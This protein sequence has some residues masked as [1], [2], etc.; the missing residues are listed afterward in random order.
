M[1]KVGFRVRPFLIPPFNVSDPTVPFIRVSIGSS[2]SLRRNER[3]VYEIRIESVCSGE[4]PEVFSSS[5]DCVL[6]RAFSF[7]KQGH[8]IHQLSA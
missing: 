2:S 8:S 1:F 7:P 3:R 6:I 5:L 4:K